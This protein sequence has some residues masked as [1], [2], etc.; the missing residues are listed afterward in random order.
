M[1]GILIQQKVFKSIDGRYAENTP[2]DKILENDEFAYSSI[3]LNLSDYVIRKVGKQNSAKALW[4]KLEELY[5]ESSLP[6]KLFLL[7]NFFRYKLDVSKNIDDNI[8]DFTKLIQHIKLIGD[9]NIDDYTPIVLLNAIPEMYGDMKSAIKYGRD[10]VTLETV[11][12]GF[13]S[14]EID[15][16]TNKPSH[17]NNEVN[18]V[19]ETSG[20]V[21]MLSDVNYVNSCGNIHEWIVDS[22]CTFHMTLF[23]EILSNYKSE[24]FVSVS[25][26]NEKRYDVKGLCDVCMIFENGF[27]LILKNVRHVPD[28]AHNL[29]S[30]S[31][32]EE[33]GLEGRWGKG[34]MKILK[35]SLTV[36]KAERKRN[37]YVC[38][39][40]YDS[41][42]ASVTKTAKSDLW[43][44]RLGH[45]SMKGLEL[46][47]KN[48]ILSEKPDDLN[49]CDECVLGKQHKVHFPKSPSPKPTSTSCILDYVHTDVWGP[50]N[51]DTHG[52]TVRLLDSFLRPL[53]VSHYLIVVLNLYGLWLICSLCGCFC[54]KP[55]WHSFVVRLRVPSNQRKSW[56]AG[57]CGRY[58]RQSLKVMAVSSS[59][60]LH[61]IFSGTLDDRGDLGLMLRSYYHQ[62]F[63]GGFRHES[64]IMNGE[65]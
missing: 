37:L 23:K 55:L 31:A 61:V 44:K 20:E 57:L 7:E 40:K 53:L 1:K 48:G 30:C 25:M 4:D 62:R 27:K 49:L 32:L 26:A 14:K 22:G 60:N 34:V 33:E 59:S 5:I 65:P 38:T 17:S 47:H 64:Q 42:T 10:N 35:G 46:L 2:E 36:F 12:S 18:F 56:V 39:V 41:F 19:R 29:I 63:C 50:A 21:Y 11:I 52:A 24:N 45:I 58:I 9:K 16:K 3:I 15:L 54:R 8:D 28:L 51:V 6:N 43:H 13:K